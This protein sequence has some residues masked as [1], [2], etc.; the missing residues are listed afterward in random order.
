VQ[1]G[2]HRVLAEVPGG[3]AGGAACGVEPEV[4]A[5]PEGMQDD[6]AARER[7]A[8]GDREDDCNARDG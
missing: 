4:L 5:Q 8:R 6:E 7:M 3:L 2:V 1:V